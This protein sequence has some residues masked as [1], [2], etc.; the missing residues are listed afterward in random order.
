M[1]WMGKKKLFYEPD[2][3][4]GQGFAF[5]EF[6]C[7]RVVRRIERKGSVIRYSERKWT[8]RQ[9]KLDNIQIVSQSIE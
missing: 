7:V 4:S 5:R 3:L 8:D 9:D 6:V 2:R 1:Q